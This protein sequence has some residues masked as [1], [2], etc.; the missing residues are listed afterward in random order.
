MGLAEVVIQQLYIPPGDLE[1]TGA[2]A[3]D[4]LEAED[5]ATVR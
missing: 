3:E 2:M 5:I 4:P 1:R